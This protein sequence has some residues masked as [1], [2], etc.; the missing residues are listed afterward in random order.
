MKRVTE[1]TLQ[2]VLLLCNMCICDTAKDMMHQLFDPRGRP[3]SRPE[4]ITIFAQ[5]VRTYV[6]TITTGQAC[7]LAEWIIDDSCLVPI[8]FRSDVEDLQR[9]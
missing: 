1:S 6:A 2:F 9:L 8:I 5:I 3:Q 4:I 7:G